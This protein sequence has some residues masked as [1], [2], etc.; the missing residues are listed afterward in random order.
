MAKVL[1]A[2]VGGMVVALGGALM[3][4]RSGDPPAAAASIASTSPRGPSSASTPANGSLP[5]IV[6]MP[7]PAAL[8]LARV[9]KPEHVPLE[10]QRPRQHSARPKL[11]E[12]ADNSHLQPTPDPVLVPAQPAPAQTELPAAPAPQANPPDTV[13]PQPAQV[14]TPPPPPAPPQPHVVTLAAGTMVDV[15]VG[16][17]LSTAHNYTGDTFRASLQTPIILDGFIIAD[18]GSK[19]LGRILNAQKP[20]RVQGAADLSLALTELN[21]TDGQQIQINT[22]S[23]DRRGAPNTR[24]EAE[25]IGGG[26]ALGAIIGAIGGGGKGA[27]IGAGVGGAAGTGAVLLS[28]GNPATVPSETRLQFRLTTPVTI[29]E[30]LN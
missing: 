16:E 13:A 7:P 18:R 14:E 21:T 1:A 30:K 2:F 11:V 26:A 6:K 5:S 17:T 22:D 8:P 12:V 19:V 27:A 15:R 10:I 25:K 28:H 4:V 9:H 3:Y 29:T 20:G 23:Y 24:S